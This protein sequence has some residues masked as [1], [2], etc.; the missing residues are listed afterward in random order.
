MKC[1]YIDSN[2]YCR[3]KKN[4]EW[5]RTAMKC[6]EIGCPFFEEAKTDENKI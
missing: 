4:Q 1:R 2:N 5:G 3:H 6:I